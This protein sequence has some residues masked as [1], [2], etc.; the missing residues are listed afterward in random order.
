[1]DVERSALI[2]RL[3]T[4]AMAFLF[5]FYFGLWCFV[6]WVIPSLLTGIFIMWKD[7]RTA[8]YHGEPLALGFI[9]RWSA[10]WP[11]FWTVY[12]TQR[13]G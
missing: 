4:S 11:N 2:G 5:G 3:A 12:L 10:D 1:M 9:L 6:I 7:M 13:H 8:W